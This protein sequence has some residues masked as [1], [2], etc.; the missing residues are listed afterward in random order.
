MMSIYVFEGHASP[1]ANA[2]AALH[3]SVSSIA[4]EAV[5]AVVA[6]GYPVSYLHVVNPLIHFPRRFPD[7]GPDHLG[8]G[9]QLS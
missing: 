5:T 6:H 9:V 3:S 8:F 7:E 1:V 4:A 2:A